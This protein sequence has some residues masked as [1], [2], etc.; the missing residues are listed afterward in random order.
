MSML[1]LQPSFSVAMFEHKVDHDE[2]K[3]EKLLYSL[4]CWILCLIFTS[5]TCNSRE[6]IQFK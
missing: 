3:K 2:K 5:N 4:S 1:A 6:L